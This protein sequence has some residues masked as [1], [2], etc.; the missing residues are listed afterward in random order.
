MSFRFGYNTQTRIRDTANLTR[1]YGK[2]AGNGTIQRYAFG[3]A[4]V[5]VQC[6]NY[7][8]RFELYHKQATAQKKHLTLDSTGNCNNDDQLCGRS[9]KWGGV[10]CPCCGYRLRIRPKKINI[11][12]K[13]IEQESIQITKMD[14]NIVSSYRQ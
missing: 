10:F 7:R 6:Y 12:S 8:Q 11:K 9:I 14:D 1:Q 13:V 3:E 4:G 2:A 5:T